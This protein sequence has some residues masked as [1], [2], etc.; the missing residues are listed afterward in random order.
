AVAPQQGGGSGWSGTPVFEWSDF[1]TGLPKVR[2]LDAKSFR[3]DA[4][5]IGPSASYNLEHECGAGG[6]QQAAGD[7]L[8]HCHIQA[9]YL[10]GM[11]SFWRVFDT[12]QPDLAVLPDRAA[13]PTA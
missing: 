2:V 1:A 6:C 9:H 4:Q 5:T 8:F 3:L 11:W 13:P 12:R 7:F 10:S